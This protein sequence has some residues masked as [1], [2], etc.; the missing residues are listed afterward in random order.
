[1]VHPCM[2]SVH[3]F[4]RC[5]VVNLVKGFQENLSNVLLQVDK[6]N[7]TLQELPD[8]PAKFGPPFPGDGLWVGYW[9]QTFNVNLLF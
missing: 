2:I 8:L 6:W 4:S 1:M 3:H 7:I 9:E 5:I